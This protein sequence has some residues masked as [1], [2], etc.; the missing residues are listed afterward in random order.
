MLYALPK[1]GHDFRVD[2]GWLNLMSLMIFFVTE[3]N[4]F[5]KGVGAVKCGYFYFVAGHA[6]SDHVEQT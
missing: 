1:L 2:L 6:R 5:H 4:I 3:P